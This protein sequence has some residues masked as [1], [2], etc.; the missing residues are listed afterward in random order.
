VGRSANEEVDLQNLRVRVRCSQSFAL[1]PL[2]EA[3][4]CRRTIKNLNIS[5][6]L[7][8]LML[9]SHSIA[10]ARSLVAI[11]LLAVSTPPAWAD[12][13]ER[14]PGRWTGHG[15]IKMSNGAT[16][17]VKCVA[18]YFFRKAESALEH[19]LRCASTSF[20][21]DAKAELGV[22]GT[23]L[24]GEWLERTYS[25]GGAVVGQV[26]G[27]GLRL[28]IEGQNFSAAMRVD[29]PSRCRHSISIDPRSGL[30]VSGLSISLSKGC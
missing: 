1:I 12:P 7:D 21:I 30:D 28:D 10:V 22:N 16:E 20:R 11:L 13:M 3:A 14:L 5:Q 26:A 29:T 2:N 9:H 6:Y 19:N 15:V 24:S 17:R 25:T 8:C 4:W 18:T 27:A 23:R